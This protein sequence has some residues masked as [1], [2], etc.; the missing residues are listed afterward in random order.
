MRRLFCL[1]VL[2]AAAPVARADTLDGR[3]DATV[4]IQGNEIPFRIDF[5]GD[6]PNFAGTLFDGDLKVTSTGGQLENGTLVVDFGHYLTRLER[7]SRTASSRAR[8]TAG[9]SAT[10]I[11]API[12]SRPAIRTVT[13]AAGMSPSIDGLW[14]IPYKSPKGREGLAVHRPPERP[15]GLGG[16]PAGGRRHRDAH[17]DLQ[18]RQVRGQ[19]LLRLAAPAAGD[20]APQGRY[21]RDPAERGLHR[22]AQTDRLSTSRRSRQ[23]TARARRLRQAHH[24]K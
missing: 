16:D 10:A 22:E 3:W 15:R 18:G 7:T 9:S 6:G 1:A 17:R 14:E 20:H 24:V 19:P 23:G 11:S 12:R 21:A 5:S 4:T 13:A 8:S 2:I